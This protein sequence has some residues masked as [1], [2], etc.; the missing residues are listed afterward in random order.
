MK[1]EKPIIFNSEMVR[2]IL[3]DRKTQ[4]RRFKAYKVG[5]ILWVRET[6]A[7]FEGAAGRGFI[8]KADKEHIT[9][10]ELCI[11][12]KW[13]PS[14]YMPRATA[15]I[16]LEVK[17]VKEEKIQDITEKDARDEG[18]LTLYKP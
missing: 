11:P 4:T 18:V 13:R 5:D 12:D 15:R 10:L 17:S 2:A 16:F 6:W 8:Y 3:E 14:I 9:P 7:K 1:K